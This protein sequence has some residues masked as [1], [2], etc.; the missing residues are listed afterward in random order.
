MIALSGVT[1]CLENLE[2]LGNYK[3]VRDFSQSQ[4]KVLVR[5]NCLKTF[6]KVM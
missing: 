6:L 5:Y 2:V 3:D 4:G 1:T